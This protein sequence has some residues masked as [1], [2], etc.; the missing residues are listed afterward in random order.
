MM[1]KVFVDVGISLDGFI[2]GLNGGTKNPLGDGGIKKREI[3]MRK[4]IFM[5]AMPLN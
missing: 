2:A 1:S 4:L 3:G 5:D